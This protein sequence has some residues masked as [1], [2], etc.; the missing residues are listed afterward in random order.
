MKHL[1]HLSGARC[2]LS[3]WIACRHLLPPSKQWDSTSRLLFRS[4]IAVEF[5]LVLSGFVTHWAYAEKPQLATRGGACQ[6][7]ARR[8]G[9]VAFTAWLTIAYML[10]I[11]YFGF[12]IVSQS[13]WIYH[14]ACFTLV[15]PWVL[16]LVLYGPNAN[17]WVF[18]PNGVVWTVASLLPSWL[19]YPWL[20][21]RILL[22]AT[23]RNS[24]IILGLTVW[25]KLMIGML[26]YYFM[27]GFYIDPTI[28]TLSYM[29]PP[30][31]FPAFALGTIAAEAARRHVQKG[32]APSSTSRAQDERQPLT[33]AQP[34][35]RSSSGFVGR[36]LRGALA[37]LCLLLPLLAIL[38]LPAYHEDSNGNVDKEYSNTRDGYE[39][40]L[41][42]AFAPLF[43]LYLYASSTADDEQYE[44]PGLFER[45]FSHRALVSL[46]DF[47]FVVYLF[48]A[49][50]FRTYEA[51]YIDRFIALQKVE[52]KLVAAALFTLYVASGLYAHFIEARVVAFLRRV[53]AG[54]VL[55]PVTD[56]S[57][58]MAAS[59]PF[60]PGFGPAPS[61][62]AAC[63]ERGYGTSGVEM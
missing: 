9:R 60:I 41:L 11:N 29:W 55:L 19:L 34:Q 7:Y 31:A 28:A 18:C 13:P 3:F 56:N 44:R 35:S 45:L 53:S 36:Y 16:P 52:P 15:E 32:K 54:W 4:G 49:P 14:L 40:L 61:P 58:P 30:A 24:L 48:Q 20:H 33:S 8:I 37:D 57:A 50:V 12:G 27:N 26:L 2:L 51:I 63:T 5:F 38:L 1:H 21:H 43:A 42:H 23:S 59:T 62:F 10:A 22:K 39:P 17:D 6:L 46:G 25:A 47:S